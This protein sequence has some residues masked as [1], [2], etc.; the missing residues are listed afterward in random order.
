[1]NAGTQGERGLH[2][3]D[4]IIRQKDSEKRSNIHANWYSR[5]DSWMRS[6]ER[7]ILISVLTFEIGGTD[8]TWAVTGIRHM[9][10]LSEKISSRCIQ[11]LDWCVCVYENASTFFHLGIKY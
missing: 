10:H 1:M 9:K 3:S 2:Q 5:K 8:T 4:I 7:L 11:T 6:C